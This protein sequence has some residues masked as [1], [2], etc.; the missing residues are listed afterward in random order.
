MSVETQ[1]SPTTASIT[2][3]TTATSPITTATT[4][5]T[6]T[7]ENTNKPEIK[8]I[9]VSA[10]KTKNLYYFSDLTAR[11]L[12]TEEF[13]NI[14]GLG[15]AIAKVVTTIDYLKSKDVIKVEKIHTDS[16]PSVELMVRVS[17]GPKH[18]EYLKSMDERKSRSQLNEEAANASTNS[19]E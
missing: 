16:I 2:S 17:K 14:S 12:D 6:T 3:P 5:T 15:E 13:V 7:T 1:T 18:Q 8:K 19:D 9:K 10:E 4:T 11:Y